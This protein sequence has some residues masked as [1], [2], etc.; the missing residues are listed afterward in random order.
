MM[1]YLVELVDGEISLIAQ[2][3]FLF[4]GV[5]LVGFNLASS[6][7]R[8]KMRVFVDRHF[9][10]AKYDYYEEWKKLSERL[11]PGKH[12]DDYAAIALQ[13][14]LPIFRSTSGACFI[15]DNGYSRNAFSTGMNAELRL[16][17]IT[18]HQQFFD[19]MFAEDWIYVP[20][21]IEPD[22]A[23]YNNLIPPNLCANDNVL[24][25]LPLNGDE[26]VTG[27]LIVAN[28]QS[29]AHSHSPSQ[30]EYFNWEDFHLLKL[31]GK[32]ISNFVEYQ[33]LMNDRMV[34][35]QF[36]AYHQFTTFVMHDLKNLIAQQALV[37]QNAS[38]FMHNP[39]FVEDAMETIA[40][41]V[42]KMNRMVLKLNSKSAIDLD[43][44]EFER[45]SLAAV[46]DAS[47]TRCDQNK[48]MPTV[49]EPIGNIFVAADFEN[50][51]MAFTHLLSNAQEATQNDGK[52]DIQVSEYDSEV[53]CKITD[54]GE[55]MDQAFID[56][57]LFKPFD[58]TKKTLG[59]GI[60]AYQYQ[61]ILTAIG[62]RISVTS[63]PGEG[64]CFTV[65][66]P[67]AAD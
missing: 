17:D 41:S 56:H 27:F 28:D 67:I 46:I 65:T 22:K 8:A 39:E 33:I 47:L 30:K 21:A 43:K 12:R 45:V 59:M 25:I 53:A 62:G 58:S 35:Q 50:L 4:L 37:V 13:A 48:P 52:I 6:T 40:H 61:Q 66:L 10:Q 23:K 2:P 9:F 49:I 36:D 32:Q 1:S 51:T 3:F 24:F 7:R 11:S 29:T 55:G 14:I 44:R 31:V 64:S 16:I 34:T 15:N 57:R 63:Q 26:K 19:K 20:Q 60:G 54:S 42:K 5:L 38:R 18:E